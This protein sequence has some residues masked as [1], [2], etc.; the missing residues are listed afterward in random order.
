MLI[1]MPSLHEG[2]IPM[3]P[4][5]PPLPVENTSSCSFGRYDA[6][7]RGILL[8]CANSKTSASPLIWQYSSKT[9]WK[10]TDYVKVGTTYLHAI[11]LI[12]LDYLLW[13]R[14]LCL[15]M[16]FSKTTTWNICLDFSGVRSQLTVLSNQELYGQKQKLSAKLMTAVFAL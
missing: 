13:R 4:T 14:N 15:F 3:A 6:T 11:V 16:M 5:L 9:Q 7:E 12:C 2:N 1:P 8:A 10:V